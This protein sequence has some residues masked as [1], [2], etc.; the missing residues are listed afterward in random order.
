MRSEL[1]IIIPVY[2]TEPFLRQ[3]LDSVL[4]QPFEN[5]ELI[6]VDDGSTDRSLE[7][8]ED[9]AK[10]D[11]RVHIL[12]QNRLHAG[13]ARNSGLARASGDYVL[14]LDSDD[15]MLPGSL[16][17][18]Q[19]RMLEEQADFLLFAHQRFDEGRQ[20]MLEGPSIREIADAAGDLL[21]LKKA[22]LG[23]GAGIPP[24]TKIYRRDFLLKQ[25]ISFGTTHIANDVSF[26]YDCL[27]KARKIAVDK[28]ARIVYRWNNTASLSAKKNRS[29]SHADLLN[30]YRLAW[31]LV[32]PQAD[33]EPLKYAVTMSILGALDWN[34]SRMDRQ[35]RRKFWQL[36]R[37]WVL[38]LG[39]RVDIESGRKQVGGYAY[40]YF[41]L[42]K[43]K[44]YWGFLIMR[45]LRLLE[46]TARKVYR[47]AE[48][49]IPGLRRLRRKLC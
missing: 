18:L 49:L 23:S 46:Q 20:Q 3:C 11:A 28:Q 36:A 2:N 4:G 22:I 47:F 17:A 15:W 1:S 21:L 34:E 24:W 39:K 43:R 37:P 42:F 31:D 12:R 29:R 38:D 10:R 19:E 26:F 40:G 7:I 35:A 41:L 44:S 32:S 33:F 45:R 27:F 30:V 9:Y 13:V 5:L 8:L 6:C 16:Q 14:F 48:R 25:R